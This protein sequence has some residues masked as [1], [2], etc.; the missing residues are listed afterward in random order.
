M[1][2]GTLYVQA[3][4]AENTENR[5]VEVESTESARKTAE[6]ALVVAEVDVMNAKLGNSKTVEVVS[7]ISKGKSELSKQNDL[8]KSIV[9]LSQNVQAFMN[10]MNKIAVVSL[11]VDEII[12]IC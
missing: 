6:S 5:E 12:N 3:W 8:F 4:V 9:T 7:A 10:F 11:L 2:I 1:V